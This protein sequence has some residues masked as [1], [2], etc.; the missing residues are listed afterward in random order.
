[1][2]G[3]CHGKQ[4]V[5]QLKAHDYPSKTRSICGPLGADIQRTIDPGSSLPFVGRKVG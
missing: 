1:M 3:T 5:V 4:G 2:D